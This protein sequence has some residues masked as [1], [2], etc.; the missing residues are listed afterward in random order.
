MQE[1]VILLV[2]ARRAGSDSMA[3]ALAKAGYD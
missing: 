3:P 2:E 1:A